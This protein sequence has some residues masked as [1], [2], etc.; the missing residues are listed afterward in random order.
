MTVALEREASTSSDSAG[1]RSAR[2]RRQGSET[3]RRTAR[4]ALRLLP[5]E[6][7]VAEA[8]AEEF[9]TKSIQGFIVDALQP[10]FTADTLG[11]VAAD[12]EALEAWARD[13]GLSPVQALVLQ[14][15]ESAGKSKSS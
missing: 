6:H 11:R 3:R 13:R 4:V 2:K 10:V 1:G 12:P 9:D 7:G 8:L 14:A 15:L 5:T